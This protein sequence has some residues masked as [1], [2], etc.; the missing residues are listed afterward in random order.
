MIFL[1]TTPTAFELGL[2]GL[3]VLFVV[4]RRLRPSLADRWALYEALRRARSRRPR[5]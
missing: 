1:A 3:A 5:A 2:L 4:A